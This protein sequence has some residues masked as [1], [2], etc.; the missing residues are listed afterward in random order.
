MNLCKQADDLIYNCMLNT[1]EDL[2]GAC[3]SE[4]TV[5]LDIP[6][7]CKKIRVHGVDDNTV[8]TKSAVRCIPKTAFIFYFSYLVLLLLFF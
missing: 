8:F 6:Q 4:W 2:L 5:A 3:S 1:H 7:K